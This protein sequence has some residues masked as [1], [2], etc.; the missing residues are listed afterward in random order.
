MSKFLNKEDFNNNIQEYKFLPFK[1]SDF[2]HDTK[3][4]S[5]L[6]GE[7]ELLPNKIFKEF[8]SKNLSN[9]DPYYS[10][11][12]DKHFLIDT[13]TS[14]A[15]ELLPL[16]IKTK[17]Q[18]L[19][20]FTALHIFV[21]S[22]RCEHSCPY[23]QVS[24]QSEDKNSFD[25]N[26]K[27]AEKALELVFKSPST[28]IKIEFQGGEPLLNFNLVKFIVLRAIEK[29]P[30]EK[31]LGFVIATN[32]AL[33]NDE[34][35]EF[36][37]NYN[38]L[39][40]TSLDGPRE[41]HNKNRPRRGNN[42]YEK[43][44]EGINLSRSYLGHDSVSALMTTTVDSLP[45]VE[46]IINEYV[47]NKFNGIFLRPLSP[48]GFAIKTK[49]YSKYRFQEWLDFYKK[50]L[51][52]IIKLNENGIEFSEYFSQIILKKMLTSDANGYVD[53]M[54]PAGTGIAVIVYNYDGKIYASDEGRMLAE[55]GDDYFCLGSVNDS[56]SDIFASDKLLDLLENSFTKS[57][58][59]CSDC[60]YEEYCGADPV[61]HYATQKDIVGH[62]PTSEFCNRN[63][64]I[65]KHLISLMKNSN[66]VEALFR[67]WIK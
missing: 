15:L 49:S 3:I 21:V 7:F 22:L 66:K 62:K 60:V 53:L 32:L 9:T 50:G 14:V 31:N 41:L 4:I 58:P 12:R 52:Y 10:S 27:N 5:N 20:E 8:T 40:S 64:E 26:E 23:C 29:K 1:F 45:K 36:C 30:V 42:S 24:R 63:I 67:S 6:I 47:K 54:N 43:T 33:I 44:I 57:S 25:M 34:I 28:N 55:S 61:F 17:Y 18:M 11:L 59:L 46:E 2:D 35:L 37:S 56:Y 16:K 39:I 38:I 48:H 19:A 51:D 65:F 13:N